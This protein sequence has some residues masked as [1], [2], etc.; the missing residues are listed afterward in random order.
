MNSNKL[1][2][3]DY[4]KIIK[5]EDLNSSERHIVWIEK[6]PNSVKR[7]FDKHLMLYDKETKRIRKFSAGIGKDYF[8]R[9]SPDGNHLAFISTRD[10]KPQLFLLNLMGGEARRI[11]N[12]KYEI[13]WFEWSPDST[14]IGFL[15]YI[16]LK[17]L[18][19]TDNNRHLTKYEIDTQQSTEK[20]KIKMEK[21]PIVITKLV[22]RT[23]TKY[24]NE[25][26]NFHIFV[27]DITSGD[28]NRVSDGDYRHSEFTWLNNKEI[29]C[30]ARR[31]EPVDLSMIYS[32]IRFDISQTSLGEEI[33]SVYN[34]SIDRRLPGPRAHPDGPVLIPKLEEPELF[35]KILKWGLLQTNGDCPSINI[36]LD[37]NISSIKWMS[38]TH[39]IV[40]IENEGKTEL[41]TFDIVSSKFEIIFNHGALIES[42][43]CND[44][45]EIYFIEIGRAHV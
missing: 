1:I 38:D 6:K 28:A 13:S 2:P 18:E 33:T 45:Q 5:V 14:K 40:S 25:D 21:D 30:L 3:T 17:E 32:V 29:L 19:I 7:D 44:N 4:L 8:P 10:G 15:S 23:G 12:S 43:D 39:A 11:T 20:E 24:K 36:E 27:V 9:F 37:R 16:N 34:R 41:R 26:K 42:F 35:G 31:E 22:Y